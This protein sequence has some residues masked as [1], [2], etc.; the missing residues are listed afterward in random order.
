MLKPEGDDEQLLVP[1]SC[2]SCT[3]VI[4]MRNPLKC[5]K[6]GWH[7]HPKCMPIQAIR[8]EKQQNK[9]KNQLPESKSSLEKRMTAI[10]KSLEPLKEIPALINRVTVVEEDVAALRA[11]QEEIKA[12]LEQLL[13]KITLKNKWKSL[14]AKFRSE[15]RLEAICKS[16]DAAADSYESSWT[17]YKSLKFL[18]DIVQPAGSEGNLSQLFFKEEVLGSD[19]EENITE[20]ENLAPNRQAYQ[21]SAQRNCIMVNKAVNEKI[22]RKAID[23]DMLDMSDADLLFFRTLAYHVKKIDNDKK[24][25]F[26]NE[27][28]SVVQK[29]VYGSSIQL[30]LERTAER[31]ARRRQRREATEDDNGMIKTEPGY[32]HVHP[33]HEI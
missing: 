19:Y 27:I 33:G 13:M 1:T 2:K 14:V 4:A 22:K 18:S 11:E 30:S 12:K 16:G 15:S 28:N 24:L 5:D 8:K 3:D 7:F 25:Q 10:E 9:M 21:T 32:G 29:Y 31:R 23:D 17:H 26:R 6:C 20:N